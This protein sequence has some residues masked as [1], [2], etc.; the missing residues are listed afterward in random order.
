MNIS[1][2][3]YQLQQ[4]DS[5]ID[6]AFKRTEE[7]GQAITANQSVGKSREEYKQSEKNYVKEKIRFEQLNDEIQAKKIKK[8]Q[9][10]SNLYGGTVKNP[11]ELQDLQQEISSLTNIISRLEDDLLEAL[12]KLENIEQEME[13]SKEKL[14]ETLSNFETEKALL[15]GEKSKLEK[16]M[17]NLQVKR[18]SL[19]ANI[20]QTFLK[21]YQS[22][23]K[24]RH[25]T[26]VVQLQDDSC[27]GCGSF[28]T[29]SQR[30]R[31]RSANEIF[32][33]PSC[34]RIVYGS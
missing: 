17:E 5:Q 30:Q 22:L 4:I 29:P 2:Q 34:H 14:T 10:E 9:S 25:G 8:S 18:E 13:A 26:A 23:R 27:S 7:I 24:S 21:M 19:V 11:K 3:L 28:L 31:A 33:C 15:N 1:F 32:Y 12:I 6:A 20:D 16:E